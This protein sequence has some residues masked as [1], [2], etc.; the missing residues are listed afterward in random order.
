MQQKRGLQEIGEE[1]NPNDVNSSWLSR[2]LSQK[3]EATVLPPPAAL[4]S[5]DTYIRQF[6]KRFLD[7]EVDYSLESDTVDPDDLV[8]VPIPKPVEGSK[9]RDDD[10]VIVPNGRLR[11]CNLPYSIDTI[12]I[13][14]IASKL[15]YE[16]VTVTLELDKRTSLFTGSANIELPPGLNEA[17]VALALQGADFGGRPIRVQ[18]VQQRKRRG[19]GGRYFLDEA[20]TA[21]CRSCDRVGH[22]AK[23][24]PFDGPS[25]PCHL[26]AG[27]DH[28]ASEVNASVGIHCKE[29]ELLRKC[30]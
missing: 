28:D 6:K 9:V 16:F 18:S 21:K 4:D 30:I 20:I 2:F 24:C 11:F 8:I 1:F 7:I 19:S 13:Q 15:G 17:S 25:N 3:R 23:D 26:C 14:S 27:K 10:I 5:D 29:K 22:M 12:T